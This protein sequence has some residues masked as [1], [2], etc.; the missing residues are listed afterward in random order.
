M[1]LIDQQSTPITPP[2]GTRPDARAE[3]IGS[4]EPATLALSLRTASAASLP[5]RSRRNLT[6]PIVLMMSLGLLLLS[7]CVIRGRTGQDQATTESLYWVA[8]AIIFLPAAA[9]ILAAHTG[10]RERVALSLALPLALQVSRTVLYPTRF[11]FHDELVHEAVLH[12]IQDSHHLFTPNSLLPVTPYYPGLEVVTDGMHELTGLSSHTAAAVVLV[13]ARLLLSGSIIGIVRELTGSTRAGCVASLVYVCNPQFIFFNGQFSYQTLALPLAVFT[14]YLV[15]TRRLPGEPVG[16]VLGDAGDAGDAGTIALAVGPGTRRGW[17]RVGSLRPLL[18]S[19]L[20]PCASLVTVVFSH[21]LT[22]MLLV[23]AVWV[24]LSLTLLLHRRDRRPRT[25]APALAVL[26]LIGTV[27]LLAAS[28]RPGNTLGSYLMGIYEGS[29]GDIAKLS[30]GQQTHQMFH[31]SSG[32]STPRWQQY[33]SFGSILVVLAGLIPALV[34][35]RVWIRRR[36]AL[37]VVLSLLA[38]LYP[39]IPAGHLTAATSEVGDRASGFAFLGVGFVV[40]WLLDGSLRRPS[41]PRLGVA[42]TAF[43]LAFVGG[44]IIGAGPVWLRVPGSYLVSADP[45]SVDAD[46]LAAAT[47]LADNVPPGQQV[48][49]DRVSGLLAEAVGRQ[50]TV[51]HVGSGIDASPVLLGPT[52]TRIDTRLIRRAN[53]SYVI[54][55]RRDATD[56]PHVGVYI[57]SGELDG[58]DRQVPVAVAAL[59]KFSQVNGAH[60]IYDNGSIVIYDVRALRAR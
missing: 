7:Y 59:D 53:L 39:V 52:D 2:N 45:R 57:E 54:V 42:T 56:L 5:I 36:V 20:L 11:M 60:R 50:H 25:S 35:A 21:H 15:L 38:L 12:H 4:P 30:K 44:E 41:L 47:W 23:A 51:R 49:A 37:A 26:G 43:L 18:R 48:F 14:V 16:P 17:W 55:D 6:G 27:V 8:L 3:A 10:L 40:A 24:W 1:T 19:L 22:S 28:F 31:D 9:R 58:E 32:I 29:A 33:A 13:L 34:K 46:S